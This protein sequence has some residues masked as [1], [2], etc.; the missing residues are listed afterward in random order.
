[1]K[2]LEDMIGEEVNGVCFVMDYV[3][4]HFNGP[5]LRALS[6]TTLSGPTGSWSFPGPGSRDAL[7]STIGSVVTDVEIVDGVE[8]R[9]VLD[10][11]EALTVDL[12]ESARSSPEAAHF[13]PGT[14]QPIRVW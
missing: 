10:N 7:C 2:E 11:S 12:R 8:I 1:M 4:F 3:E 14:N 9:L 5:I 13:V 6:T